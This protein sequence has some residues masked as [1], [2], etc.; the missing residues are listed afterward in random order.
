VGTLKL[1]SPHDL[2][3]HLQQG[4]SDAECENERPIESDN[5]IKCAKVECQNQE[6]YLFQFFTQRNI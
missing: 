1:F 6:I 4:L 3:E 5:N 2:L